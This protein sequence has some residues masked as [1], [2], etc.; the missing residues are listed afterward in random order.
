MGFV[1]DPILAGACTTHAWL[2]LVGYSLPHLD[3][4]VDVIDS[5]MLQLDAALFNYHYLAMSRLVVRFNKLCAAREN[6]HLGVEERLAWARLEYECLLGPIKLPP[7]LV[8]LRDE[9]PATPE[10]VV[11]HCLQN[12]LFLSFYAYLFDRQDT[13]GN[14]LSLRPEPGV[15][16]FLCALARTLLICRRDIVAR[17]KLIADAQAQTVRVML[18][19]WRVSQFENCRAILSLWDDHGEYPE[20]VAHVRDEIGPGP[21][22]MEFSDGYSVFWTFRDLRSLALEFYIDQ[23]SG[24]RSDTPR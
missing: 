3:V 18:R 22:P 20:L 10:S 21:W 15:M 14:M 4:S 1:P 12:L 6:P 9:M 2:R 17:W 11:M 24:A 7:S 8:D 23:Y 5:H 13:L 16:F 19:L